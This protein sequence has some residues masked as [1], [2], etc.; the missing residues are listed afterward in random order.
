ME[1]ENE[2]VLDEDY[3]NFVKSI[4]SAN[5]E[6]S[7]LEAL[8]GKFNDSLSTMRIF[9]MTSADEEITPRQEA[10]IIKLLEEENVY[11]LEKHDVIKKMANKKLNR[12]QASA[13]ISFLWGLIA[14]RTCFKESKSVIFSLGEDFV[15]DEVS[16]VLENAPIEVY[17]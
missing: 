9:S 3:N 11:L 1:Q 6:N 14:L 4:S 2:I 15:S 12:K 5:K 8:N 7:L 10:L 13:I 17:N 16:K